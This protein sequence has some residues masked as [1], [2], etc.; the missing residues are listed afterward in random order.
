V[1]D[2]NHSCVRGE[3]EQVYNIPYGL[4]SYQVSS[5]FLCLGREGHHGILNILVDIVQVVKEVP[6]PVRTLEPD[7]ESVIH[8]MEPAEGFMGCPL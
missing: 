3:Y 6:Q 7:D 5:K 4:H 2:E 1:G 8:V